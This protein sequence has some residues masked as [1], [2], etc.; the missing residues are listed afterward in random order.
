[1]FPD[2]RQ[3]ATRDWSP[4]EH[5]QI[6]MVLWGFLSGGTFQKPG[7]MGDGDAGESGMDIWRGRDSWCA[8]HNGEKEKAR[9]SGPK[10]YM[11]LL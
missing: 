11:G 4:R 9:P 3:Q 6:V 7:R 2:L 1:M 10:I 8:Q 5:S